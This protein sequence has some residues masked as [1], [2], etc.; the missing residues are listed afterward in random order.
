MG[1]RLTARQRKFVE[2]YL[3]DRNATQA[4]IRAGYKERS[5]RRMGWQLLHETPQVREEVDAAIAEQ[6]RRTGVTADQVLERVVQI[7]FAKS[8]DAFDAQG[9]MLPPHRL[10][11]GLAA[12][13]TSIESE[14]RS[15]A[16]GT[17]PLEDE[18]GRAIPLARTV[19][20]RIESSMPALHLLARHFR[21]IDGEAT[22]ASE[23]AAALAKMAA[24]AGR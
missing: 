21:L 4:A 18:Q 13:V 7:A 3:V 19:R 14:E 23:L 10:P 20:L 11:E 2:E 12:A 5:S 15:A 24:G 8:T 16:Q 22:T 6:S 17:L 1:D 9:R